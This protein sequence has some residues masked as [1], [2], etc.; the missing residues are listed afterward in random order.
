M[1][2]TFFPGYES[3][4]VLYDTAWCGKGDRRQETGERPLKNLSR[5]QTKLATRAGDDLR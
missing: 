1:G 3:H 5:T 2:G 4:V